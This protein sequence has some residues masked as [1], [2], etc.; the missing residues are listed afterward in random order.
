MIQLVEEEAKCY[1]LVIVFLLVEEEVDVPVMFRL[2][3]LEE[4]S[5]ALVR[6]AVDNAPL[7]LAGDV[8]NAPAGDARNP[9]A[10]NVRNTPAGDA[11]NPLAEDARNPL[12]GEVC[13]APAG[14]AR[15]PLAGDVNNASA[16]DVCNAPAGDVCNA[17]AAGNM[18]K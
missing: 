16:G 14:D 5:D 11:R 8:R 3:Q 2:V 9:L 12:A 17:P 10:G 18:E 13:N 7:I 4:M 1:V 6:E 15:N